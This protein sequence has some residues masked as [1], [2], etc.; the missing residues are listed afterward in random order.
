MISSVGCF[1]GHLSSCDKLQVIKYHCCDKQLLMLPL[2]SQKMIWIQCNT[3]SQYPIFWE[4]YYLHFRVPLAHFQENKQCTVPLIRKHFKFHDQSLNTVNKLVLC[5]L[6]SLT[7]CCGAASCHVASRLN[8]MQM[9]GSPWRPLPLI[10]FAAW[11]GFYSF[12]SS[13]FT[14]TLCLSLFL[15]LLLSHKY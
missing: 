4:M 1:S 7:A 6:G 14:H 11:F 13:P 3:D 10:W 15:L 12:V 9:T 5:R 8:A 2:S